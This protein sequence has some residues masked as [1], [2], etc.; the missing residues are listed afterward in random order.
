MIE[1]EKIRHRRWLY[2][3]L[4]RVE[5]ARWVMHDKHWHVER[6]WYARARALLLFW[7]GHETEVCAIC[8]GK[9]GVVWW[10]EDQV[11]WETVTGWGD[12]GI[13]CVQCFDD[14][15]R[16]HDQPLVQ[17]TCRLHVARGYSEQEWQRIVKCNEQESRHRAAYNSGSS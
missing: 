10:C 15:A 5:L 6:R 12:G 1:A 7:L 14:L 8:G 3:I 16:L 2:G 17:W 9:V 13:S 4:R 11:L